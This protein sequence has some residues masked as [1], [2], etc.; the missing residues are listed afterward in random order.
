MAEQPDDWAATLQ[1]LLAGDRLAFLKINRIIT[2]FLVR[3]NAYD[4]RDEWEDLRQEVVLSIVASAR[5]GRLR[6]PQ[7]LLAFVRTVTRNKFADRLARAG[8]AREK[9]QLSLEDA[10]P[11]LASIAAAVS[12]DDGAAGEVWLAAGSLPEQHRRVLEGVYREGQ[13]YEEVAGSTGIP[14]GTVKRRLREALSELRKRFA[15]T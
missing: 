10:A 8:R 15:E 14:L 2:G 12:S 9:E 4:Y 13:T 3:L 5:A 6:D 7:A 1:Q 11:R